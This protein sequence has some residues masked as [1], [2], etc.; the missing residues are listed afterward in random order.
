MKSRSIERLRL[1]NQLKFYNFIV[2]FGFISSLLPRD[3]SFATTC[4]HQTKKTGGEFGFTRAF[5]ELATFLLFLHFSWFY[6]FHFS[7]FLVLLNGNFTLSRIRI[8]LLKWVKFEE[9]ESLSLLSA[10]RRRNMKR[11]KIALNSTLNEI[12]N[13]DNVVDAARLQLF[14]LGGLEI[15]LET[16]LWIFW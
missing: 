3:H 11:Q 12:H 9:R 6:F 4:Y 10:D 1:M 13:T 7:V 16:L 15:V 8:V 2:Q 14:S 5:T